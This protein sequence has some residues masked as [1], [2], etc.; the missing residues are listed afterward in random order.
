MLNFFR[1]QTWSTSVYSNQLIVCLVCSLMVLAA[2][3]STA[4]E[5]PAPTTQA[6]ANGKRTIANPETIEPDEIAGVVVDDA[7]Q[8]LEGVLVDVWSWHPGD[9]VTTDKDGAFRLKVDSDRKKVEVRFLKAGYS[10]HYIAQQPLGASR[11][12]VALNSD[13]YLEGQVLGLDGK[14]V[15]KTK[16]LAKQ[17]P[18][19]GDGV[20][21]T[22]VETE[23]MTDDEGRYRLYLYPD[24]YSIE[25]SSERQGV[26]KT[27]DIRAVRKRDHELNLKLQA[28]VLFKARVLDAETHEPVAGCVLWHWRSPTLLGKSDTNGDLEIANL[29]P[30]EQ[31]FN[32]GFGEPKK[33]YTFTIYETAPYGRWWSPNAIH[34]HQKR[35]IEPNG[36]QRNFDN[37]TIELSRNMAPVT[38][39][40][41]K[42]VIVTGR[43]TDPEGQP[44]AGAT[45]A[46]ARTGSGNSLTGDTRY[47]VQTKDDGTYEVCLPASGSVKYNLL[48]HDGEYSTWRKF[49]AGVTEPI[50]TIPGQRIENVDL[51][52]HR[53]A[54]VRGR[55][56]NK[57]GR[58]VA[59]AQVRAHAHD[60]RGNRYYDPTTKT[61]DDGTFELSFIRPGKHFIQVEPFW[62]SADDAPQATTA[63]VDLKEGE[64]AKEISLIQTE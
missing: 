53:P 45:V 20:L 44:V 61:K 3:A 36:W 5:R 43:V 50:Q 7:G 56:T 63:I 31:E 38:I 29:L 30:G 19:Q 40:V 14:P 2:R 25:V 27:R 28:G 46:P 37:L 18:Q 47:S 21:I 10:P 51:Q 17:G 23:T 49:A 60:K 1:V 16:V 41:E 22:S 13:T 54:T 24:T 57:D 48:A 15:A 59:G 58:G 34:P 11:F 64:I 6:D 4:E 26:I 62:L 52:L 12:K 35:M 32:V 8:P 9:E 42:G 55:V 33:R 39:Y